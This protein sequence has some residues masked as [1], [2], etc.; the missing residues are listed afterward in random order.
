[1]F[2]EFLFKMFKVGLES[3][4]DHQCAKQFLELWDCQWWG[5]AKLNGGGA[6]GGQRVVF[7]GGKIVLETNDSQ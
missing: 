7:L 1:M 3:S 4:S 2:S 5:Q 6:V